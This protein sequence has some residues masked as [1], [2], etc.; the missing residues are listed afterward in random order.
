MISP[1]DFFALVPAI[2]GLYILSGA[3]IFPLGLPFLFL[4]RAM[5]LLL[6]I[7]TFVHLAGGNYTAI[8]ITALMLLTVV[9]SGEFLSWFRP[10]RRIEISKQVN[11]RFSNA[12]KQQKKAVSKTMLERG[13]RVTTFCWYKGD[14]ALGYSGETCSWLCE[15]DGTWKRPNVVK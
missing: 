1:D 11:A 12:T 6:A 2:P 3:A 8:V 7:V 13:L 5:S 10:F 14:I 4:A 15:P 9:A